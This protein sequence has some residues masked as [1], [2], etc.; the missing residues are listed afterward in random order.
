[1]ARSQIDPE[2]LNVITAQAFSDTSI[3]IAFRTG[4]IRA[5]RLNDG[6][7]LWNH[8]LAGPHIKMLAVG[9]SEIACI[10]V[11]AGK[12]EAIMLNA[13]DGH[14]LTR[15]SLEHTGQL[16]TPLFAIDGTLLVADAR[17]VIGYEP[18]TLKVR[19][20]WL[21]PENAAITGVRVRAGNIYAY[22]VGFVAALTADGQPRWQTRLPDSPPRPVR[23]IRA[24]GGQV[25]VA[26]LDF[27]A[28]LDAGSGRLQRPG[29][30]QGTRDDRGM[31]AHTAVG[32][33]GA[34]STRGRQTAGP[35]NHGGD[36]CSAIGWRER[37]RN[38]GNAHSTERVRSRC[39]RPFFATRP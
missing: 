16:T 28:A 36:V 1:M 32:R 37:P 31:D 8:S 38:G 24:A 9:L 21:A 3:I 23:S 10:R 25:Y 5:L 13:T 20:R 17:Q 19:W 26:G 18:R 12:P 33:G 15:S 22:G 11:A 6:H 35:T 14:E 2:F 27:I 4:Q 7:E 39:A 34:L 30:T 29:R